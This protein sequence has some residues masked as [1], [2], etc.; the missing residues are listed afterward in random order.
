MWH[1]IGFGDSACRML[2]HIVIVGAYLLIYFMNELFTDNGKNLKI[3]RKCSRSEK[4]L[5]EMM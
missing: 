3:D 2:S 5:E 1:M 4:E